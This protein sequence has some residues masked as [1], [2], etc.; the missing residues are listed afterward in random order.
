MKQVNLEIIGRGLCSALGVLW[1]KLWWWYLKS[2]SASTNHLNFPVGCDSASSPI[3]EGRFQSRWWLGPSH[4]A[5]RR[6]WS[7]SA[8]LNWV[9]HRGR[10]KRWRG[11]HSHLTSSTRCTIRSARGTTLRSCLDPCKIIY[12]VINKN[13]HEAIN[14]YY[15]KR[16][17]EI[18]KDTLGLRFLQL[19]LPT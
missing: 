10:M 4:Q 16:I 5:R 8:C 7:T 11:K 17:S 12:D 18:S 13:V 19:I 1:L 15:Q 9:C 2:F 6:R 3:L 14:L